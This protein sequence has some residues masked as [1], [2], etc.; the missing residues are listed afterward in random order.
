MTIAGYDGKDAI[1][2]ASGGSDSRRAQAVECSGRDAPDRRQRAT[3]LD[4]TEDNNMITVKG[5]ITQSADL[6]IQ[7]PAQTS[8]RVRT[9]E[10]RQDRDRERLGRDR[11]A[12]T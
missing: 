10:R 2:E 4:V 7:V 8:L 1:I 3:G 5:G 12:R 6:M 11:S 9:H